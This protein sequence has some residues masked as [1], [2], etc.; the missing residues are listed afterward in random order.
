MSTIAEKLTQLNQVKANI[1]LAIEAKG[2]SDV[3]VNFTLYPDKIAS[4]PQTVEEKTIV[5]D[6]SQGYINQKLG[7]SVDCRYI[8]I[9][10][11]S[12]SLKQYFAEDYSRNLMNCPIETIDLTAWDFTN[13]RNIEGLFQGL[14]KLTT[15]I[16]LDKLKTVV[17][18]VDTD[19]GNREASILFSGT[20][21]LRWENIKEIANWKGP[22]VN[23]SW[24]MFSNGSGID[25]FL[26]P[27]WTHLS[28][29]FHYFFEG[30][31]NLTEVDLSNA[32]FCIRPDWILGG[33]WEDSGLR[34]HALDCFKGCTSLSTLKLCY[35]FFDRKTDRVFN[36]EGSTYRNTSF[37]DIPWLPGRDL[38]TWLKDLFEIRDN[39]TPV[40]SR[41]YLNANQVANLEST[42]IADDSTTTCKAAIESFGWIIETV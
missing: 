22:A 30:C 40:A 11:G 7:T 25:K 15:I 38:Y 35:G 41:L 26:C 32:S 6:L 9:P 4:I 5:A 13:I 29:G 19:S 39:R 21:A 31:S 24:G 8:S 18:P 42:T 1:K 37:Q 10:Q 14:S 23:S 16:G 27:G 17:D 2:V 20:K 33:W 3:G 12:T 36:E 28:A 34:V